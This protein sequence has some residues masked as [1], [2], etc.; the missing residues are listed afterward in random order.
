M[1]LLRH[2]NL[3]TPVC[4]ELCATIDTGCQRMAIGEDTLRKFTNCLPSSLQVTTQ[5]QEHRFRSVNGTT[6]TTHVASIP[7]AVGEKGGFLR[8]AV[9]SGPT[10]EK[11]PFLISRPF[12]IF[13]KTTLI[14]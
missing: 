8:P 14:L 2:V 7:V 3:G 9:F 6:T 11:A 5:P 4:E 13:C 1:K 12:L 10:C